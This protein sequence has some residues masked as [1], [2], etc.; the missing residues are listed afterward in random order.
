MKTKLLGR[1]LRSIGLT[2]E[3]QTESDHQEEN[4][5]SDPFGDL[6]DEEGSNPFFQKD[7]KRRGELK[8]LSEEELGTLLNQNVFQYFRGANGESAQ[9][10]MQRSGINPVKQ[11]TW[12]PKIPNSKEGVPCLF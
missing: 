11:K 12:V 9:E 6:F 5:E 10:E 8:T 4:Y 3:P 7:E 1:L 2:E